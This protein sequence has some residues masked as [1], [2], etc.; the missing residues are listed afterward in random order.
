MHRYREMTVQLDKL[1]SW[2]QLSVLGS[3]QFAI[4]AACINAAMRFVPEPN[5]ELGIEGYTS[6]EA[7]RRTAIRDAESSQLPALLGLQREINSMIEN[8]DGAGRDIQSTFEFLTHNA[9]SRATFEQEYDNRKRQGLHPGMPK[10]VFVD[11]EY[12][13]AMAAHNRLV[14]KGEEAVR[15][16]ETL[17]FDDK[18]M[19]SQ[20]LPEW[21]PDAFEQKLI[22]KLHARWEKLELTRTNPRQPKIKRD[23]A[24]ADQMMIVQVLAEYGEKPGFADDLESTPEQVADAVAA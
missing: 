12:E 16:C 7:A 18:L 4:N 14:A 23:A 15:L 24:T 9:P 3:W 8:A 1:D 22:A 17:T 5:D 20:N 2:S 13:R 19:E 11:H 21:I 10:K 6:Y